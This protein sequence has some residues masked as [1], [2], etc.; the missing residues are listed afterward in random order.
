M[1]TAPC[2][3]IEICYE[4]HGD[5]ADEPLVL[6]N[7]AG[8]QLVSW[9]Q[10]FVDLIVAEGFFV[11]T[12]DNRDAGLSTKTTG[13]TSWVDTIASGTA[14]AG[15]YLLIDMA[16]DL[17]GLLDHLGIDRAHLVG[18]SLGGH[19][20]QTFAIHFP[21]RLRSLA[22]IMSSTNSP[23]LPPSQEALAFLS[24]PPVQSREE[25]M[26]RQVEALKIFG[27]KGPQDWDEVRAMAARQ[28]DR[29]PDRTGSARQLVAVV[30]S[31][32]RTADLARVTA[33]TVVI[34]G[35]DDTLV[36]PEAGEATAKAIPG[37][38]LVLI[39]GMGHDFP[40]AQWSKVIAA[41]VENARRAGP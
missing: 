12:F 1:P 2:N 23:G 16:R 30:T 26:E 31:G 10:D 25:I 35:V 7:G 18:A 28:Y 13:P 17:L 37:A 24:R 29:D 15:G 41:I 32:D 11:V 5:P 6:V 8:G 14:P 3:G 21:E 36:F 4:V 40:R 9:G 34:H 33:P 22:S 39:D 20:V 27:G 19:I 38:H